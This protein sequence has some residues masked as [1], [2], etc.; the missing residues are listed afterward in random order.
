M[1]TFQ[2]TSNNNYAVTEGIECK[3]SKSFYFYCDDV[4][5]ERDM[6]VVKNVNVQLYR[7]GGMPDHLHL[8]VSLPATL[9]MSKFV[10]ELKVS[11]SKW[12]KA[13]PHF[14]LFTGWSKEFAG[15]SY[16]LRDKEMIVRYIAKQKEHHKRSTF[17]EEYRQFLVENGVVIKEEYF[18]KD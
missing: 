6:E 12:M 18:L 11:T 14:P 2:N 15:F 13:N 10:Q 7:I 4:A 5:T 16:N 8:F 17:A 3:G 9:A 1:L